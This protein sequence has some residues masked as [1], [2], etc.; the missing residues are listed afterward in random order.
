MTLQ[1]IPPANATSPFEPS[2]EV[3]KELASKR[4]KIRNPRLL[5]TWALHDKGQRR[6]HQIALSSGITKP[7]LRGSRIAKKIQSQYT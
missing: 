7:L 2:I 4:R 1:K 3:E 6:L 5:L